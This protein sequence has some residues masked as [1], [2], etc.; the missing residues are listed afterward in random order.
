MNKF[1]QKIVFGSAAAFLPQAAR[2]QTYDYDYNY[3][4]SNAETTGILAGLGIFFLVFLVIGLLSLVFW[5]LMLVHAIKN[6][7]PDKNMWLIIL[8]V[9]FVVGLGLIG[10][11]VYYFAVKRKF[12]AAQRP[13]EPQNQSKPSK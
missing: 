6:E 9:S 13:A 3:E 5:I 11:L 2:A 12:T 10:A 8:L 7:I 4:L 1:L